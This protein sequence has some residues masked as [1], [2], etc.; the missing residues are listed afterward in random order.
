M[1]NEDGHVVGIVTSTAAVKEF[2]KATG[3]LPQNV[4]WAIKGAYASLILPSRVQNVQRQTDNPVKN[5]KKSVVFIE[6]K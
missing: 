3:A 2:Y 4:N 1:V 5:T 6:V